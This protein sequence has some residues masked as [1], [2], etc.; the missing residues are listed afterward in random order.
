MKKIVLF[1]LFIILYSLFFIHPSHAI[2]PTQIPETTS[3][4]TQIN[5]LK[6]RIASR[7]A[8]LKLVERRGIIGSVSGVSDT[9]ITVL[10]SQNNNRFIDVDELT[11]FSSPSAK[12]SFGISDIT[13]NNTL[14]ILGLYNKQS[15]HLLARFVNIVI[16]P[17]IIHGAVLS[18]DS[19][20]FTV[21]IVDANKKQTIVDVENTTRSQQ[22]TKTD[23]LKKYGFSKIK[24]RQRIFVVGFQESKDQGHFIASRII[25]FPDI[26]VNPQISLPKITPSS[27]TESAH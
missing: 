7:V 9:Q 1:S 2:S 8:E 17:K 15:R 6:D 25:I 19:D 27:A 12:G 23:G 16:L 10:D 26:P 14:G 21:T 4:E 11:K 18:T 24:E 13:K 20:A 22:Y 3:A 5:K